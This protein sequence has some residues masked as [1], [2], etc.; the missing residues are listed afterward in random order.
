MIINRLNYVSN[1][2]GGQFLFIEAV[3]TN[4][5]RKLAAMAARRRIP[6]L[7]IIRL[8]HRRVGAVSGLPLRRREWRRDAEAG[9][10]LPP[11]HHPAGTAASRG[12]ILPPSTALCA[13]H[14]ARAGGCGLRA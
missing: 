9:G 6:P 10:S 7:P 2:L 5:L 14:H 13:E 4:R 11:H 3:K 1:C 12:R 8:A